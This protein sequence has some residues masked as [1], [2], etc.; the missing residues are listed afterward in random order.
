MLYKYN[1][2][3]HDLGCVPT[4]PVTAVVLKRH[5][6][7]ISKL[8]KNGIE[9]AVHGY[10]HCDYGVLPLEEQAVHFGKAIDTFKDCSV[11]FTG[12]RAPFLRIND[13]TMEALGSCQFAYDSSYSIHWDVIDRAK[14]SKQLWNAYDKLFDFYRPRDA[15]K[16]LALP[17]R[18]NGLVEIP[19]SIP[20]DEG[21][22]ERL[23]I[24]DA[25]EISEVWKAIL[26]STYERG[27]LFTISLHPERIFLCESALTDV[28]Q[29]ARQLNP[30]VW[31][32]TLREIAEW[33]KERERFVFEISPLSDDRCKVRANCSERATILLRNCRVN[34]PVNAWSKGYKSVSSRDFILESSARPVVGVALDSSPAA[35]AFLNSEGFIVERSDRPG[36]YG[37]YFSNLAKFAEVDEMVLSRKLEQS[38]A[39]L[40][41][42]WRWPNGARSA[43]S[44]TGD[45]DSMTLTDFALRILENWRQ[46]RRQRS[47][48]AKAAV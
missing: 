32:A 16:Y 36:D 47:N 28:F 21:M 30:S 40:L 41:R 48:G 44:V 38:A 5:P 20:D 39:P 4:L 45:I 33:W 10:I 1:A 13:Q 15:E 27:E 25:R 7:I 29:Q 18:L 12:F 43:L 37:I 3:A 9:F 19:V 8:S 17:R 22:V 11:T 35:V 42:Y 6:K 24:K 26:H 14:Y 46:N 34:V 31:V 23:G 2:I